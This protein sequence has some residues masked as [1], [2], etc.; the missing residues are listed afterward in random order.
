LD[1]ELLKDIRK[2]SRVS[3]DALNSVETLWDEEGKGFEDEKKL[4]VDVM[5]NR[6]RFMSDEKLNFQEDLIQ[7]SLSLNRYETVE[8]S[9]FLGIF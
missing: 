9:C 8:A 5:E 1:E 3:S 7:K 6:G 4:S 2:V